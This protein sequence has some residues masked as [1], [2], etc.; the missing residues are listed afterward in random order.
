MATQAGGIGA[1]IQADAGPGGRCAAVTLRR[2]ASRRLPLL[3]VDFLPFT[4]HGPAGHFG[5]GRIRLPGDCSN[6]GTN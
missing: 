6:V 1:G 2:A 4:I 3:I 5:A